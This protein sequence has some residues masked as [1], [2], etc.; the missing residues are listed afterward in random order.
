MPAS[1]A[2]TLSW[3]L[4]EHRCWKRKRVVLK[5]S[6]TTTT[7]ISPSPTTPKSTATG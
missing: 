2:L 7:T 1:S 4:Q 5:A 6:T 3:G